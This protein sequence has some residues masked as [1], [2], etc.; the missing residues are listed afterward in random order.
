MKGLQRKKGDVQIASYKLRIRDGGQIGLCGFLNGCDDAAKHF[1]LGVDAVKFGL[2][3]VAGV[4]EKSEPIGGFA[5]L[6]GGDGHF[7][8]EIGAGLPRHCRHPEVSHARRA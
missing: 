8:E 1:G 7:G 2:G 6:F 4:L 3:K 5:G